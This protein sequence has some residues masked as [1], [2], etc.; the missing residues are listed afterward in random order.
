METQPTGIQPPQH[1]KIDSLQSVISNLQGEIIL[2][3]DGFDAKEER[4]EN[5]I[6]HYEM[7]LE[8]LK[9]N[10]RRAYE[11]FI[12]ISQFKENYDRE[13]EREFKKQTTTK[14]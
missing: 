5:I 3:E 10:H 14:F 13:S 1:Q 6:F 9:H 4:Y 12:R 8:Y 2:L 11:D 7:S